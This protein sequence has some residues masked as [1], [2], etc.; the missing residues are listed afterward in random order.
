MKTLECP[1]PKV[2]DWYDHK[3]R[4][5]FDR[6]DLEGSRKY[7]SKLRHPG[8]F[9][10]LDFAGG[11]YD[12]GHPNRY[13]GVRSTAFEELNAA[14][15]YREEGLGVYLDAGCGDSADADIAL[16]TGYS[17]AYGVDLFRPYNHLSDQE[18][19]R[20]SKRGWSRITYEFILGDICERL[21]I[22]SGSID[23]I[24]SSYVIPLMSRPDRLLFYKQVYRM[25][26]PGGYFSLAAGTLTSGYN[27]VE[28]DEAV[29]SSGVFKLTNEI[30]RLEMAGLEIVR[31]APACLIAVKR[32]PRTG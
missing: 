22:K 18:Y 17:K 6:H 31:K 29:G 9:R 13:Y 32:L 16:V 19:K 24:S 27:H 14:R 26:K 21:P 20:F 7:L 4:K 12:T 10:R 1:C 23:A 3:P 15:G 2:I 8:R 28:N 30:P 11:E 5:G 25:L